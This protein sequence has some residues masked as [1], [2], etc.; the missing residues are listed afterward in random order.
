VFQGQIC[1][2]ILSGKF[3]RKFDFSIEMSEFGGLNNTDTSSD[4]PASEEIEGKV[5]SDRAGTAH[6]KTRNLKNTKTSSVLSEDLVPA[7]PKSSK[8][9]FTHFLSIR[10]QSDEVTSKFM[11]FKDKIALNLEVYGLHESLLQKPEKFHITLVMLSLDQ[12]EKT[13]EAATECLQ[14]FK[15]EVIDPILNGQPL[16]LHLKGVDIMNKNPEK[17]GV[18]FAKIESEKLQEIAD[19]LAHHFA[20]EGFGEL[21]R[22]SVKLHSTLININFY[23]LSHFERNAAKKWGGNVVKRWKPF[24]ATKLLEDFK[25]FDF[26]SMEVSEIKIS[27]LLPPD[28]TGYYPSAGVVKLL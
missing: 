2:D 14:K 11:E 18:V 13:S 22:S 24:N 27:A 6:D 1:F 28:E 12:A 5:E 20:A 17:A 19:K 7:A 21:E 25:D 26:G 4:V 3:S 8:K 23:Q 10:L 15:D 9:A 16:V